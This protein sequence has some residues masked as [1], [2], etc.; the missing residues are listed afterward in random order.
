MVI[1]HAAQECTLC[2]LKTWL[3]GIFWVVIFTIVF[4][5]IDKLQWSV[6]TLNVYA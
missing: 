6:N 5:I 4:W 2:V 1:N 3:Q